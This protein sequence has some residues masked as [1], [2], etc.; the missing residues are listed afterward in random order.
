MHTSLQMS[1]FSNF[2]SPIRQIS[3]L[4]PTTLKHA[5]RTCRQRIMFILK[6]Q[7]HYHFYSPCLAIWSSR[8]QKRVSVV[9]FAGCFLYVYSMCGLVHLLF[10][11]LSRV[12][13]D[14]WVWHFLDFFLSIYHY[15]GK[16]KSFF[17]N[18][19]QVC[20][21][22]WSPRLGKRELVFVFLVHLFVY[23]ARV[24]TCPFS[25]P[26]GVRGWLRL[27]TPAPWIFLLTF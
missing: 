7:L 4:T 27:V 19:I 13:S 14:L 20:L 15:V 6:P 26:L 10:L 23:V 1:D 25:L 18:R 24:D 16:K 3:P 22:L 21:A 8:L 11:L 17:L 9:L 5:H 12:G 2:W